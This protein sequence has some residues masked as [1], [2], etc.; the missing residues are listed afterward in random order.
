MSITAQTLAQP[1]LDIAGRSSPGSADDFLTAAAG[2]LCQDQSLR[3]DLAHTLLYLLSRAAPDKPDNIL[4]KWSLHK[5]ANE[6]HAFDE[7]I[8]KK[9]GEVVAPKS[10]GGQ[11]YYNFIQRKTHELR[12]KERIIWVYLFMISVAFHDNKAFFDHFINGET[13]DLTVLLK[14]QC[15]CM[16][17]GL[18]EFETLIDGIEEFKRQRKTK[19]SIS[20]DL[21]GIMEMGDLGSDALWRTIFN[22]RVRAPELYLS[23]NSLERHFM[24]YRF[25]SAGDGRIVKSFFVIQSPGRAI[26]SEGKV[27]HHFAF[28]LFYKSDAGE[29][30]RSAGAVLYLGD[31]V[32]FFGGSR[33]V[34]PNSG[35]IGVAES[36]REL[37]GP[38]NMV[39]DARCFGHDRRILGGLLTTMNE[40]QTFVATRFICVETAIEHSD[41]A[42]IDSYAVSEFDDEFGR[43]TVFADDQHYPQAPAQRAV[44]FDN[45]VRLLRGDD[46]Q[47][48]RPPDPRDLST[49]AMLREV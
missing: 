4:T 38:K 31:T 10:E 18:C 44:M 20:N 49:R 22:R 39:I 11:G 7:I 40:E 34:P 29:I 47:F 9:T 5:I 41:H 35:E 37:I 1:L 26:Q 27:R 43:F 12:P 48:I 15:L 23:E 45:M 16:A 30:R 24:F 36:A 13:G 21:G 42:A 32:T 33:F 3:G 2:L 46:S 28:K 8:T 25:S 19:K 6:I 14:K 17:T